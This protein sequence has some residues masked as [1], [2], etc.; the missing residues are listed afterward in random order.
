MTLTT[1]VKELVTSTKAETGILSIYLSVDQQR[2]GNLNRG[3]QVTFKNL[4]REAGEG[5]EPDEAAA[6][7]R[8][9]NC[10]QH[11]MAEYVPEGKTLVLFCSGDGEILWQQNLRVPIDSQAYWQENAFIRP[12]MEAHDEF[13]RYAVVVT[14]RAR[15]RLFTVMLNEIEENQEALAEWNV[16]KFDSSTR[17]RMR[18][19]MNFQRQADEH[20]RRHLRNVAD[21]MDKLADEQAFDRLV[22]AGVGEAVKDLEKMLSERLKSRYM[23]CISLPVDAPE[24]AVLEKTRARAEETERRVELDLVQRLITASAKETTGVLGLAATLSMAVT[25]R[26]D[27]LVYSQNFL[28]DPKSLKRAR[29]IMDASDE[30]GPREES[31]R[32]VLEWLIERVVRSGGAIEQVRGDAAEKLNAEG[33][34]MGA[35]LRY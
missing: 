30:A 4:L 34:G 12:L 25:G 10:A 11:Y 14:D 28:A 32:D 27:T 26:I 7:E 18:S 16:R 22:L 33:E 31:T 19:Q 17:D 1:E 6:F 21:M 9:V 24:N 2:A 15:A 3:Y 29:D 20:A 8:A 35:F 5:V 23:G 13:Q